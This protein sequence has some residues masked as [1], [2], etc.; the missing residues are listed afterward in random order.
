[1]DKSQSKKEDKNKQRLYN[2]A[3]KTK[4]WNNY[5]QCHE[6][7]KKTNE[8]SRVGLHQLNNQRRTPK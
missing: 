5:R 2:Q 7:C 8:E 6:E 3:K 4:K 1:M